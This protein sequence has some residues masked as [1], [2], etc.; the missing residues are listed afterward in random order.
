MGYGDEIIGT[1][2]ARGAAAR[3]KKIAFGDGSKIS[4]GPWCVEMFKHNPNIAPP[5][6]EGKSNIEWVN[7]C[8]G[9]R[10]YNKLE[11]GK[12][13]WNY[14]FKVQAGEFYFDDR[15]LA[16]ADTYPKGFVVIEPNVPWQKKVAPNKDWGEDNY[17]KV[18]AALKQFGYRVVQFNHKNARRILAG[19]QVINAPDF[20]SAISVLSK[21]RLYIGPEGG[22]HHAAAA[23]D[24]PAVVLFGGFIPPGVMGYGNQI[25]LTGGV[26]ACGNI[27]PCPHC[28]EAMSRIHVDE[29][30]ESSL[31]YLQ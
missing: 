30:V 18:F 29:V 12:W 11:N 20:R 19:A 3:G 5:G 6:S 17:K 8:K 25:C 22:M 31:R 21:A 23:V 28:R 27:D 14:D 7:H 26:K 24:V 13:V 16:F 9:H 10:L 1:G 15:E 2:L 4:W